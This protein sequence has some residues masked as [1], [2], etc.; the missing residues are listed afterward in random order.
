[1]MQYQVSEPK[2]MNERLHDR[3]TDWRVLQK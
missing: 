1:M 3:L 2:H